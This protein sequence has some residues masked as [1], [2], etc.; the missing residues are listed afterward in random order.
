MSERV[1]RFSPRQRAEH[2]AVIVLFLAL[3]LTGFPQRF[4]GAG[5]AQAT[6]DLLGGIERARALHRLSG[7][8]FGALLALHLGWNA[9]LLLRGRGSL[10]IVPTRKDFMDVVANL[11]YYLRLADKP[12]LF[13]RYDYREKFEYWGLLLGGLVMTLTGFVLY[14]PLT[15]TRLLPG[16]LIPVAKVAHS[17]EGLLAFLVV[18]TWH[19]YN[20][21]FSP[22][23]FPFNTSIF[24]GKI[25]RERLLKDHPLEHARLFPEERAPEARGSEE[26]LS[27]SKPETRG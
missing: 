24:T 25:S 15:V 17:N 12:P 7:I 21:H 8:L 22:E 4:A 2:A 11:R 5:W 27:S 14:F 26:A 19:V 13:D 9:A 18:V 23:V 16:E 20:A 3:A 6:V 1:V 10:A